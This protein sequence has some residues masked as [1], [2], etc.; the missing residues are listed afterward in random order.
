MPTE[1]RP[2]R[3]QAE[4]VLGQG[5]EDGG[6]RPSEGAGDAGA[7]PHDGEDQ[8]ALVVLAQHEVETYEGLRVYKDVNA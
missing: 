6:P 3:R 1:P 8:D 4:R 5:P 7:L 2:E